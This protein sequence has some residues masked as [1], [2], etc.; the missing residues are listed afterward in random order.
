MLL[1]EE[2]VGTAILGYPSEAALVVAE[3]QYWGLINPQRAQWL[4]QN[5][6]LSWRLTEMGMVKRGRLMEQAI[7]SYIDDR[8]LRCVREREYRTLTEK[9]EWVMRL[10]RRRSRIVQPFQFYFLLWLLKATV[11]QLDSYVPIEYAETA[12]AFPPIK[13]RHNLVSE[14]EIFE[15]RRTFLNDSQKYCHDKS[16]Y[17][18]LYHHD[19]VWLKNNTKSH[20]RTGT[21][22][23]RIDWNGRD[24]ELSGELLAARDSLMARNGRPVKIT[25]AAI[26][27]NLNGKY[28][29]LRNISKL[30]R[31]SKLLDILVET[32]HDYQLR[33]IVWAIKVFAIPKYCCKSIVLRLAGIRI[34]RV[35]ALEIDALIDPV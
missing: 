6:F 22:G 19:A 20:C 3:M 12:D 24:K 10:I 18:W 21:R 15:H 14:A 2:C 33:K 7:K 11:D 29:F 9:N 27:K 13:A 17:F 31:C 32:E 34:A 16:G 26:A 4:V 35:T 1:P 23:C 25:K 30:S 8:F 28:N 5:G